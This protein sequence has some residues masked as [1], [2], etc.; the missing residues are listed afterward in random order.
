MTKTEGR[1]AAVETQIGSRATS[2]ITLGCDFNKDSKADQTLKLTPV[3]PVFLVDRGWVNA[4]EVNEGDYLREP[5]GSTVAVC[6][7]QSF[8][9]NTQS[10]NLDVGEPNT[11]FASTDGHHWVLVHNGEFDIGPQRP[12]DTPFRRHL[13]IMNRW[14][15]VHLPFTYQSRAAANCA[16]FPCISL[17]EDD[18]RT[19]TRMENQFMA[20][21]SYHDVSAHEAKRLCKQIF[22]AVGVPPS[23]RTFY[24]QTMNIWLH[25]RHKPTCP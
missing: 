18:H 4:D 23:V 13:P 21:R 15:E 22:D 20:G 7:V 2:W 5:T 25:N 16:K 1:L 6:A 14:L 19:A 17:T 3:H 12:S 9:T 11:F 10:F 24:F 8:T